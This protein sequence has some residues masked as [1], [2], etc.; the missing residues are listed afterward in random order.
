MVLFNWLSFRIM[1]LNIITATNDIRLRLLTLSW[2][3]SLSYSNQSMDL[4]SKSGF[5]H[6]FLYDRDLRHK[7]LK[8][9]TLFT[10]VFFCIHAKLFHVWCPQNVHTILNKRVQLKTACLFKNVW[11]FSRDQALKVSWWKMVKHTSKT[12]LCKHS[13][14][15]EVYLAILYHY[16]SIGWSLKTD[17]KLKPKTSI[18]K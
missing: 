7:K 14:S 12:L 6:W 9:L 16:A 2:R 5:W 3:R 18:K 13:K 11:P 1:R 15:F 4:Q 10:A 17:K 8:N